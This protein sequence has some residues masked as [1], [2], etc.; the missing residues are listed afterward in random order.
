MG[1]LAIWKL[2]PQNK[3]T[4]PTLGQQLKAGQAL[5]MFL[6]LKVKIVL[7]NKFRVKPIHWIKFRGERGR[8]SSEENR[9]AKVENPV[10]PDKEAKMVALLQKDS[11]V[12]WK[13]Q[14]ML[15]R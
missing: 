7:T 8:P 10:G 2:S 4:R 13:T 14:Y 12:L 11:W 9:V 1:L 3:N 5:L 6:L 15:H